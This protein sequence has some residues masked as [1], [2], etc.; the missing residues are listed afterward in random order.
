MYYFEQWLGT[1]AMNQLMA[2][3]CMKIATIYNYMKTVNDKSLAGMRFCE[4]AKK[5][6]WQKKAWQ[7]FNR[8]SCSV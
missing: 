1:S 7:S 5:S 3:I 2:F 8:K 4:S 6:L